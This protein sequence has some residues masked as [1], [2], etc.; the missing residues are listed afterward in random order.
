[1]DAVCISPHPFQVRYRQD[2]AP[3]GDG[4]NNLYTV[5]VDINQHSP[6]I[7]FTV[8]FRVTRWNAYQAPNKNY[9]GALVSA[10]ENVVRLDV[11]LPAGKKYV[12][13]ALEERPQQ[14]GAKW[15]PVS[16]QRAVQPVAYED[17]TGFSWTLENP[18]KGWA[19][20]AMID[21]E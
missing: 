9:V 18:R 21:W 5:I 19:H 13:A 17:G 3:G 20:R 1:M 2:P 15:S 8:V 7:P 4:F 14:E 6:D 11:L 10:D 16:E 12:S